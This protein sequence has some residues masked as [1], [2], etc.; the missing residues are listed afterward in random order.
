MN[1]ISQFI[2][3]NIC[4]AG[5]ITRQDHG[6]MFR[7]PVITPVLWSGHYGMSFLDLLNRNY[8]KTNTNES[9]SSWAALGWRQ[10]WRCSRESRLSARRSAYTRA[11]RSCSPAHWHDTCADRHCRRAR[12]WA[13]AHLWCRCAGRPVRQRSRHDSIS[14]NDFS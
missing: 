1:T 11:S 9:S 6:L 2:F 5:T 7:K 3:N 8:Y 13:S 12:R 4:F 10:A 14:F